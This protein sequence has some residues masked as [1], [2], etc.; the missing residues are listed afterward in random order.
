MSKNKLFDMASTLPSADDLFSTE[1]E[2]QEAKLP[3]IHDIP[4]ADIDDFPNHPFKVRN[5]ED[6]ENLT[7]S[8]RERGVITPVTV[9]RKGD[10][11]EMI[12]GHRRKRACELLGLETLRC[13]IVELSDEEATIRMCESN[14]QR[15]VILPSEKA[16]AYKMRMDALNK[17]GKRTDLTLCHSVTKL[18]SAEKVAEST[19]VGKRQIFRYI[20]LTNLVPEL[21][22]L[23]DTGKI[24]LSPAVELSYLDTE[25][26][27]DV[28]GAIIESGTFPTYDQASRIRKAYEADELNIS[29][30]LTESA[31]KSKAKY[32]FQ[33]DRL[34]PFI[35]KDLG[36]TETEDFVLKALEHY[37]KYLQRKR[38][39]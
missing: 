26:Q 28:L 36:D 24:K 16:F 38:S 20:R 3:K 6:M 5:D 27:H 22:E 21:L 25:T 31:P 30:I 34:R 2:R 12:S 23:V 33:A 29:E 4:L 14:F 15:S 8:I 37:C 1:E 7:M 19:D 9:R 18:D 39:E 35:P 32:T 11:Y 13:E 10:R 17:Q